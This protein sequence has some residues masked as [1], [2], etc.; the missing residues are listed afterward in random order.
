MVFLVCGLVPAALSFVWQYDFH[1]I[2]NPVRLSRIVATKKPPS[3]KVNLTGHC[4]VFDIVAF[5]LTTSANYNLFS[6]DSASKY[7]YLYMFINIKGDKGDSLQPL[8]PPT[9]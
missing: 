6:Y 4:V 5:V 1:G 3:P 7:K 8:V 9:W 2:M